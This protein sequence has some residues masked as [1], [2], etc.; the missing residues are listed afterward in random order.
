MTLFFF[1]IA[2]LFL[3]KL[4]PTKIYF[5]YAFVAIW[6]SYCFVN[7]AL[8]LNQIRKDWVN[9]YSPDYLKTMA[10][11]L[12]TLNNQ[13]GYM[14]YHNHKTIMFMVYAYK[15]VLALMKNNINITLME[16]T[17]DIEPEVD[18]IFLYQQQ[19][20]LK[21]LIFNRF[22]E[23]QRSEKAFVSEEQSRMDFIEKNHLDFMIADKNV[24]LDSLLKS[25]IDHLITDTKTGER[26]IVLK[27]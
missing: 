23:K 17:K 9:A 19:T 7:S 3:S 14:G 6:S 26:F 1:I 4:K 8:G 16:E 27:K 13:G 5:A 25:K 22:I 15:P 11:E 20:F 24:V 18:S 10:Q 2:I 21:I 12:K